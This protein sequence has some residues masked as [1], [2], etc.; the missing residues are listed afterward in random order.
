MST[1]NTKI[2]LCIIGPRFI[3]IFGAVL[4]DMQG[5]MN[6]DPINPG[7]YRLQTVSIDY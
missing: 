4:W 3:E 5:A 7:T 2:S 1:M 6:R